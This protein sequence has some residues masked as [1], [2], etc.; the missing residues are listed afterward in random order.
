M[1][2]KLF[3]ILLLSNTCDIFKNQEEPDTTPPIVTIISH[4]DGDSV[5]ELTTIKVEASDNDKVVQVRFAINGIFEF[6]DE[7]NLKF[8]IDMLEKLLI[9]FTERKIFVVSV[10]GPQSSRKSTLL[11]FLFGTKFEFLCLNEFLSLKFYV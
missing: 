9:D 5:F 1:E 11:N 7:D 8:P 2:I 6:I 10:I 4:Q 3:L